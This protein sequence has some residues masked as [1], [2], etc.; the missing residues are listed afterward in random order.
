M[1]AVAA[2]RFHVSP[3]AM[4]RELD[5]DPEQLA[6]VAMQLL[7][8]AEAKSAWDHAKDKTKLDEV[9]GDS[10]AMRQVEANVFAK[11]HERMV[12]PEFDKECAVCWKNL[13]RTGRG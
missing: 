1:V 9:W 5:D 2:E 10:K 4:A 13:A 8:Y 11:A 12:H 7:G 3:Y 6:F